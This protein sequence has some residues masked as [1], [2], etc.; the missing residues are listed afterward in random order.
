MGAI[1]KISLLLGLAVVFLFSW[2]ADAQEIERT[3]I[4]STGGEFIVDAVKIEW[5]AGE[6]LV[7]DFI[8]NDYRLTQGFHQGIDF[9]NHVNAPPG[10]LHEIFISPNPVSHHLYLIKK[11]MEKF[12]FEI[13]DAVGQLVQKGKWNDIS[14]KLDV[15]PFKNGLY[16]ILIKDE[17]G[18]W[19]SFKFI[20]QQ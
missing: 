10:W 15:Q 7:G 5:S 3:L 1:K 4:S 14:K 16:L 11:G 12:H 2:S 8:T 17:Q 18:A 9:V 13:Y 20:K 6:V 19:A